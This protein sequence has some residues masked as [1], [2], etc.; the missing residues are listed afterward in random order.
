MKTNNFYL[1]KFNKIYTLN[2]TVYESS[3]Q[4]TDLF[5]CKNLLFKHSV[6]DFNE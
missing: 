6:F 4:D 2:L 1:I 5:F 3:E